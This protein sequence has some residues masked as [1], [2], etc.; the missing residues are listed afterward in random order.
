MKKL[1][2]I[3]PICLFCLSFLSVPAAAQDFNPKFHLK[4]SGGMGTFHGGDFNTAIDGVNRKL[5][6]LSALFDSATIRSLERLKW[7]PDF[8]IEAI[9]DITPVLAASIGIGH[10]RRNVDTVGALEVT[11]IGSSSLALKP[12]FTAIPIELN[13]HYAIPFAPSFNVTF[14]A[15]G[16]YFLGKAEFS[17]REE[18]KLEEML[19][20]WDYSKGT[21]SAASL[22]LQGGIGLEY[23]LSEGIGL[24]LEATGRYAKLKN[25]DF[26]GRYEDSLGTSQALKG[27]WYYADVYDES[28]ED[29]YSSI[30][31]EQEN[32]SG[33][34]LRNVR[35]AEINYSGLCFKVGVKIRLGQK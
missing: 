2:A 19:V 4:L 10:L 22:G 20:A 8:S 33:W 21:G 12:T 34:Y 24:F 11:G 16:S 23:R 32:P 35:K 17:I 26:D 5:S 1:W 28:T 25:W 31:I 9:M 29:Y 30:L 14:K 13:V 18:E 3:F 7:G 27:T 6:D 15:G